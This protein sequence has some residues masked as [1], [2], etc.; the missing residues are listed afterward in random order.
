MEIID[1]FALYGL[2]FVGFLAIVGHLLKLAARGLE[3]VA[4]ELN[5][6]NNKV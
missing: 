3:W 2:A 5:R 1:A 4:G 6:R